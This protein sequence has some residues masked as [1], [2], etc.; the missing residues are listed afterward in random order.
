MLGGGAAHAAPVTAE[1]KVVVVSQLSFLTVEDL[2]FGRMVRGTTAGTVTIAPDGTKTSTG[3]VTPVGGGHQPARFAGKGSFNQFVQV[4]I[5]ATPITITRVGGGATMTVSNFVIGSTPTA[6]ITTAPRTFRITSPTGI[7][8]FPIGAR[9][10]VGA[11][12]MDGNY[13]GTF[14]IVLNYQ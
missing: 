1:A 7:F 10:N 4:S 5:T 11:N 14:T 3:G 8:N 9:L 13:Q 12:Q 2:E 6:P